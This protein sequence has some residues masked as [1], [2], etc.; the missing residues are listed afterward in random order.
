MQGVQE[1]DPAKKAAFLEQ[2]CV[3]FPNSV[4]MAWTLET[5]QN[6][7]IKA[8]QYG[9]IV[10]TGEKLLALDP[11]DP[12][13]ALQNLKASEALKDLAAIRKW[14]A[15]ASANARK[16]AMAPQPKEAAGVEGWKNDVSYAKQVDTYSEYALFRVS[17]ESRDPKAAI[18]FGEALEARNP[19]S[20]YIGQ[21]RVALFAA[22]RQLGANEKAVALAERVLATDQTDEDML[23]VVADDYAAKKKEPEKVHEYTAQAVAV[24]AAKPAPATL[25]EAGW[26]ARKNGLTSI[27][28]YLSGS[29]YYTEKKF[30]DADRE[31]RAALPLLETNA[32]MKPEVLFMLADANYNMQ[33]PR[34]AADFYRACAAIPGPMQAQAA[35]NL[36]AIKAKYPKIQ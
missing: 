7:Y 36:Q 23:I 34:E 3:Q 26:T 9:K 11:E 5:L 6:L 24:M 14:S 16:M 20:D 8:G 10:A 1:S 4:A 35:K 13:S 12:E 27:A 31:L 28:H 19:N 25:G 22:Y 2:F 29:L 21:T 15:L 33:K 17:V 30:P 32:A 18:E